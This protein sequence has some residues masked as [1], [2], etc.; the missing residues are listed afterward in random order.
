MSRDMAAMVANIRPMNESTMSTAVMSITTPARRCRR[1][2]GEVL[3][4]SA[5]TVWSC[6]S[7]W[8]DTTG[9]P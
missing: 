8:I 9:R 2:L 3:L 5:A 7:V 1:P 6:R 4:C